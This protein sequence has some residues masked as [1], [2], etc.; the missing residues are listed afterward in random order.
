MP[1]NG[2]RCES[3]DGGCRRKN[4]E[5]IVFLKLLKWDAAIINP[6]GLPAFLQSLVER[7]VAQ[8]GGTSLYILSSFVFYI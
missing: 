4:S 7:A 6:R 8:H 5:A 2:L 3:R 1:P